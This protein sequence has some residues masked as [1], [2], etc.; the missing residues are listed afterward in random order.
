[1]QN[2]KGTATAPVIKNK[3][4]R[5]STKHLHAAAAT[6]SHKTIN[7]SD[8]FSGGLGRQ[9]SPLTGSPVNT[10]PPSQ[11]SLIIGSPLIESTSLSEAGN[12]G[13][14][15]ITGV[16]LDDISS[17]INESGDLTSGGSFIEVLDTMPQSS[18]PSDSDNSYSGEKF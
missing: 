8:T 18:N 16:S 10:L 13:E 12:D 4:G 3:R 2:I 1:M 11:S 17:S 15:V 9:F 7:K 5:P 14:T 6:S